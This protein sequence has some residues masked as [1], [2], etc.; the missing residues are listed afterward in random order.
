[1]EQK[2]SEQTQKTTEKAV[3]SPKSGSKALL[4]ILGGCLALFIVASLVIG[5]IAYWSYKKIKRGIKENQ[6]KLEQWQ[7][8][9][10]KMSAEGGS[11][12]GGKE[13]EKIKEQTESAFEEEPQAAS[14]G[15]EA[16]ILPVN[17]ERQ[18]GYIKK[19]YEKNGK[20]YLD[21]DYIQ[22]LAGDAA[23]KAMR[24]DGQCPKSGECIVL[25]DYYIRNQNPLIRT[26][27][28]LP[29]AQFL[30]Q[31]YKLGENGGDISWNQE[32]SYNQ[33]KNIFMTNL[34]PRLKDVPYIVEIQS[35]KI[36]KVTEQY[37]P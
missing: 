25:D 11:A 12:S 26:F 22:W 9:T 31:T 2:Q 5:G 21:I 8:Q 17:S 32:I 19:V 30:M 36:V 6:P 7:N 24:E 23:E 16:G 29:D 37:I 28:I 18:M 4:W 20:K 34:K 14:S 3:A 35:Q 10:E 13:A 27:E 1:M 33:F 15:G